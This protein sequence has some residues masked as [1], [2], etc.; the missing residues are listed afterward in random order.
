MSHQVALLR[1]INVGGRN[2]IA[3]SELRE[4]LETLGFV[5]VRSLLQSGNL[6]FQGGR[7][8]SPA[9]ERLLEAETAKRF[10][11][12]IDY[13]VRT[14][15]ELDKIIEQNP[16]RTEAERDPGHLLVL[17]LKEAA[18]KEDVRALELAIRSRDYPR[19]R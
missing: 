17:F 8:K 7:R 12:T 18:K 6:I 10:G 16:F 9:L 3:M 11:I 13:F 14:G 1:G 15:E 19:R 4:L 2:L 5:G